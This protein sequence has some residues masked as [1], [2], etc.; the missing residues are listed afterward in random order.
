MEDKQ[1]RFKPGHMLILIWAL[2]FMLLLYSYGIMSSASVK[3]AEDCQGLLEVYGN[4]LCQVTYNKPYTGVSVSNG[5]YVINC[6]EAYI[7]ISG[8]KQ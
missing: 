4:Q 5:A 7:M 2:V 3:A 1:I 6:Q 8:G